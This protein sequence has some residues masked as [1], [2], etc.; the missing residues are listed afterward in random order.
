[1]ALV[2]A[3]IMIRGTRPLLWHRFGID[4]IP[5]EKKAKQGVAGHNPDEWRNTVL[6][7]TKGQLYLEPAY[8]FGCLRDG[9]KHTSSKRGTLQPKVAS[10]LQIADD[11]ILIDRWLPKANAAPP[12]QAES[13]RVYLDV[14]SVR[15]P[16]TRARNVRYRVAASPGWQ[17]E[18][19]IRWDNTI[20]GTEQMKAVVNDAGLFQGLGD[21]RSIGFGRFELISFELRGDTH[22]KKP[23]TRRAVAPKK[24]RNLVT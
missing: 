9:A 11:I 8:I 7:T 12:L 22:A 6:S 19:T 5:L 23:A 18:F 24:A 13:E 21:G 4:A 16:A 1:M 20:L 2:S 10:T 14:R 3:L 17:T 15:N